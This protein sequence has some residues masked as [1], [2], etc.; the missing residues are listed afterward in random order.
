MRDLFSKREGVWSIEESSRCRT[1]GSSFVLYS[2]ADIEPRVMANF[3]IP[4]TIY[5]RNWVD[6][7]V[8]EVEFVFCFVDVFEYAFKEVGSPA[9]NWE[10]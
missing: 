4:L 9:H 3:G 1:Q 5:D 2:E 6:R 8:L 10:V 7:N